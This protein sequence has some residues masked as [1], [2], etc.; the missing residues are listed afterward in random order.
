MDI[1]EEH[2]HASGAL[3]DHQ[4]IRISARYPQSVT[5]GACMK[6]STNIVI[7]KQPGASCPEQKISVHLILSVLRQ[8]IILSPIAFEGTLV[9]FV[10]E[11]GRLWVAA[12]EGPGNGMSERFYTSNRGP[13]RCAI[14]N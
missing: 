9:Q 14:P 8:M 12:L 11:L 6:L 5:Y 10:V 3:T 13:M 4:S 7:R 1:A 2:L